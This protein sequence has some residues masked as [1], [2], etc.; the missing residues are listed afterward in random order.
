MVK[1]GTGWNDLIGLTFGGEQL[2][3]VKRSPLLCGCKLISNRSADYGLGSSFYAL[4]PSKA[5]VRPVRPWFG[6]AGN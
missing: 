3:E 5:S 6:W 2:V 1:F 4:S